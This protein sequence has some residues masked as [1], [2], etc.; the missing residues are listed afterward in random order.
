M[1]K[2]WTKWTKLTKMDKIGQITDEKKVHIAK[3]QNSKSDMQKLDA[4]DARA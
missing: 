3:R 4:I 2:K 1:A